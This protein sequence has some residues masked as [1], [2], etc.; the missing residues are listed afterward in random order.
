MCVVTGDVPDDFD[1]LVVKANCCVKMFALLRRKIGAPRAV[2]VCVRCQLPA[3]VRQYSV[4][5]T[6]QAQPFLSYGKWGESAIKWPCA[7]A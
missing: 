6:G 3:M 7:C 5:R 2:A 1:V 4:D